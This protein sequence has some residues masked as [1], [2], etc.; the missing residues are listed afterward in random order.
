LGGGFDRTYP[1]AAAVAAMEARAGFCS[2]NTSIF[3]GFWALNAAELSFL[4]RIVFAAGA[5][6]VDRAEIETES[7]EQR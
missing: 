4:A 1:V 6:C 2:R 7:L 5:R 3:T